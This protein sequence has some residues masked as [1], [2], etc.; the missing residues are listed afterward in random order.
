MKPPNLTQPWTAV[1]VAALLVV[2]LSAFPQTKRL[3]YFAGAIVLLI[4]LLPY[5]KKHGSPVPSLA[6]GS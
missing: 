3:A 1:I 6:K 4:L 5:W 2:A